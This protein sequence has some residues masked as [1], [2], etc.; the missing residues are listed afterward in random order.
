M[1]ARNPNAGSELDVGRQLRSLLGK[2]MHVRHFGRG[3]L[4]WREGETS[5]LLVALRTG[6]V[7]IYRLLPTGRAVTMLIFTPGDV[8][9]FL[10]FLDGAPYP[11]Y[12]QA[13]EPV[14]AEVMPRSVFHQVL[15]AEPG[16]ALELVALL[17]R[18]LRDAFDVI[19]AISIPSARSRVAAALLALV[20]QPAGPRIRVQLPVS[21]HEFAEALGM[22]PETLSRAITGLVARGVLRRGRSGQLEVLDLAGLEHAARSETG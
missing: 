2:H 6:R 13:M 22:V 12:A 17:G 10:P 19:Q 11:A 9:G 15:A 18:R 14:E 21:S 7:K 8:F 1:T 20:P 16:L 3:Q 5:G 4:L